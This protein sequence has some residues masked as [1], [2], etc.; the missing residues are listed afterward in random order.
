MTEELIDL[1]GLHYHIDLCFPSDP[2]GRYFVRGLLEDMDK[3]Q[4]LAELKANGFTYPHLGYL[5]LRWRNYCRK[6]GLKP[7]AF[8]KPSQG[9]HDRVD[10][11]WRQRR[12]RDNPVGLY[13]A[14][15]VPVNPR[16]V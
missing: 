3:A 10:T 15:R 2:H 11:A 12:L 9:L 4:I 1:E 16:P 8:L 7:E 14:S 13:M 6:H 5:M